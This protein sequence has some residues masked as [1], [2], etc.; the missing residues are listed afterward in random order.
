ML[1]VTHASVTNAIDPDKHGTNA[2][3]YLYTYGLSEKYDCAQHICTYPSCEIAGVA[4]AAGIRA[5]AAAGGCRVRVILFMQT[6]Q[7]KGIVIIDDGRRGGGRRG[8]W[9]EGGG[10]HPQTKQ[11]LSLPYTVRTHHVTIIYF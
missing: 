5:V 10:A 7:Q 8:E 4:R 6:T 11:S 3:S 9:G 1:F 2:N